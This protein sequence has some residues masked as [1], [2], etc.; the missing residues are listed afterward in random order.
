MNVV[1]VI[2]VV[3]LLIIHTN[4]TNNNINSSTMSVTV[5]WGKERFSFALPPP[6]TKLSVIRTAISEYT[7]IPYNAFKLIYKGTVMKDD[8]ANISQYHLT[9]SSSITLIAHDHP[10]SQ[11]QLPHDQSSEQS[12]INTIS[13]ELANVRTE[14]LPSLNTLLATPREDTPLQQK[15]YRRLGE[16]LLQSLLRLDALESDREWVDAR[17]QRKAAV[18]EVQALLDRLDDTMAPSS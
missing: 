10:I 1:V 11:P 14:L 8:N 13:S 17:N 9:K 6:D 5:K 4:N 7:H 15:E 12:L 18:K 16:L 3:I 2:Q